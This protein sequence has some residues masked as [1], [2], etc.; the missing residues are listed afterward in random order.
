MV[1]DEEWCS[2]EELDELAREMGTRW[3]AAWEAFHSALDDYNAG[4]VVDNEVFHDRDG[5]TEGRSDNI[6][7]ALL[8]AGW[9]PPRTTRGQGGGRRPVSGS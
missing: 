7:Q 5:T 6:V 1:S 4:V 3:T 9:S 8:D 2:G